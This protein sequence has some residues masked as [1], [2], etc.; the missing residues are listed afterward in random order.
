MLIPNLLL[1]CFLTGFRNKALNYTR[2]GGFLPGRVFYEIRL[3]AMRSTAL[4]ALPLWESANAWLMSL[5]S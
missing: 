5:K 2:P 1:F 4:M 3:Y